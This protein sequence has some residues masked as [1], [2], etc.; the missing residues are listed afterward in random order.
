MLT[1][2][3]IVLIRRHSWSSS[4][5]LTDIIPHK[6]EST[7]LC[8]KILHGTIVTLVTGPKLHVTIVMSIKITLH[9][10][11]ITLIVDSF[12]N[13]WHGST[14]LVEPRVRIVGA[15]TELA[16]NIIVEVETMMTVLGGRTAGAGARGPILVREEVT[17]SR[18]FQKSMA[19]HE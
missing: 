11:L 18:R 7:T 3:R 8:L 12:T 15:A 9:N 10:N 19:R 4:P 17:G 1:S 5:T 6:D 14:S 16:T 13:P 2:L